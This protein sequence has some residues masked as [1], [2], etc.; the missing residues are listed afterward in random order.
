MFESQLKQMIEVHNNHRQI[1]QILNLGIRQ[2]KLYIDWSE[3]ILK[4]LE[5]EK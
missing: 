2:A 5:A 1:L 3:E 4:D